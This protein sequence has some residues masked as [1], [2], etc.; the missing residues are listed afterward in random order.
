MFTDFRKE[1]TII[2]V[3]CA[4]CALE[5]VAE[6][7]VT[8]HVVASLLCAGCTIYGGYLAYSEACKAAPGIQLALKRGAKTV[9]E[10]SAQEL[11]NIF[12]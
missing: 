1:K 4:S 11:A 6:H 9:R 12:Y 5:C 2:L 10:K 3:A 7:N 8:K